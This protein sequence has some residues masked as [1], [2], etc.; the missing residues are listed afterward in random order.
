MPKK[1][2]IN[3]DDLMEE[4]L[5]IDVRTREEHTLGSATKINVPVL[6]QEDRWFYLRHTWLVI[7]ITVNGLRKNRN[8]LCKSIDTLVITNK[9]RYSFSLF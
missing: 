4:D 9:S 7:P 3:Y 8:E 1:F 5:L 2:R 6:K